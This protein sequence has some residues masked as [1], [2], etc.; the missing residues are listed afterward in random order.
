MLIEAEG[1]SAT[2]AGA[3][4]LPLPLVLSAASP[5][6]G[7]IAGR[8]GPQLPLAIGALVVACGFLLALQIGAAGSYWTEILP[9]VLVIAL[10]LSS[11]VAPLTTTV[12]ESVDARHTGSAS[13]LNSVRTPAMLSR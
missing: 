5:I 13:G 3:A 4:L 9:A 2:A 11:A 12:L 1:Y 6:T 10:G 8:I 7:A